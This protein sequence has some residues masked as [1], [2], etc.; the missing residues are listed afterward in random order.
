MWC[1]TPVITLDNPAARGS[2]WVWKE[3]SKNHIINRS[4]SVL[5]AVF[6]L[7]KVNYFLQHLVDKEWESILRTRSVCLGQ[8]SKWG[9]DKAYVKDAAVWWGSVGSDADQ[10][11]ERKRI[12]RN[13]QE[14]SNKWRVD[15]SL[16][17][18]HW[19][20]DNIQDRKKSL[21]GKNSGALYWIWHPCLF[22]MVVTGYDTLS[23]ANFLHRGLATIYTSATSILLKRLKKMLCALRVTCVFSRTSLCLLTDKKKSVKCIINFFFPLHSSFISHFAVP[24]IKTQKWVINTFD[25]SAFI[26]HTSILTISIW[27]LDN[28]VIHPAV[29]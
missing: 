18:V 13:N 27:I 25:E 17:F 20:K 26:C 9:N 12:M 3:K 4:R 5:T 28:S 2:P 29:I 19:L 1:L 22:F 16:G 8:M 11:W 24:C 7:I 15:G 21:S 14:G 23:K 6:Q 10:S